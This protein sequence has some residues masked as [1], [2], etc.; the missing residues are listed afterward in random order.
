MISSSY[1]IVSQPAIIVEIHDLCEGIMN[2]N[3]W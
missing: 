1:P 3:F 2:H